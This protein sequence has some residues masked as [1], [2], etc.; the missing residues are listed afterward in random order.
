MAHAQ[1]NTVKTIKF[2]YLNICLYCTKLNIYFNYTGIGIGK[3]SYLEK[4]IGPVGIEM[5]KSIKKT[6][7][8]C[9]LMNPGKI[10][11]CH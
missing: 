8:P 3:I 4:E 10:F 11:F 6:F 1:E 2:F 7:D 9:W 5:M